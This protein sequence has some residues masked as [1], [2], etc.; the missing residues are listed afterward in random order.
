MYLNSLHALIQKVF[1]KGFQL[2]HWF[3]LVDEG[4][5]EEPNTTAIGLPVKHHLNGISLA[6]DD[7]DDGPTWNAGL[8]ALWFFR[9]S[10]PVAK[11]PYTFVIFQGG[12]GDTDPL[13]PHPPSGSAHGLYCKNDILQTIGTLIRLLLK[14]IH[15]YVSDVHLSKMKWVDNNYFCCFTSKSTIF[16]S[17]LF[18]CSV[19]PVLR[20]GKSVMLKDTMQY[21]QATFWSQV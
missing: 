5:I 3:F 10:G 16:Q 1:P 2:W 12:G 4:R 20:R 14:M 8:V 11:E 6:A 9:R 17:C 21:L 13:S 15:A 18:L 19:E 7:R